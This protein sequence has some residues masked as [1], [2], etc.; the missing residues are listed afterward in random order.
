MSAYSLLAFAGNGFGAL[1]G[2]WTEANPKLGWRWIQ[3]IHLMFVYLDSYP[4]V[5]FQKV[6]F[7]QGYR[8]VF[9]R[10]DSR[11]ERDPS[12]RYSGEARWRAPQ[13]DK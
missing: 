13:G 6:L 3:W 10:G 12:V 1:V 5:I 7:F 8:S 11:V 9:G 4:H 2:G